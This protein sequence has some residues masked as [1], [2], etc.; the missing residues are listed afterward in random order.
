MAKSGRA[1]RDDMR[2]LR[3]DAA[4]N[5]VRILTAAAIAIKREGEKVPLDTIARDAGVGIGTLYRRFPT[6]EAIFAALAERSYRLV[7]D[8]AQLAAGSADTA[9]GCIDFFLEQTIRHRADLVL[10]FHGGPV[11]LD[12]STTA[13]RSEI[14]ATID[15]ILRR[16]RR[17][18]TV[19][20]DVA[21]SDI[22][23]MGALLAEPLPHAPN[24][25]QVARR[26][27]RIYLDGLSATS[28]APLPGRGLTRA[29]F[30]RQMFRDR[31]R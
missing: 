4:A 18:G 3:R 29:D 9:I 23:M 2:P 21:V 1:K 14:A 20:R 22:I 26:L 10:P 27:A 12:E 6:R 7:L 30:E 25:D 5:R 28:T 8:S 16:G 19:R 24:W 11:T 13:L 17:D 15:K 31:P